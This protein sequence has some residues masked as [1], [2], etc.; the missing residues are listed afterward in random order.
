M[1]GTGA[2]ASFLLPKLGALEVPLQLFGAASP[3]L[4]ALAPLVS[5]GLGAVCDASEVASHQD[6][7]VVCKSWQ[8]PSKVEQLKAAPPPQRILVLQNGLE[9]ERD[10]LPLG[11][12]VER[13]LSTYGV[14]STMPG[15]VVGG[16][17]GEIT[18][19]T[20]SPWA[21]L[22]RRAGL[23]V[24]E[25]DNITLAIWWKLVVNASLNVVAALEGVRNGEALAIPT[26]RCQI[27]AVADEVASL[28]E[29]IG[30]GL[31]GDEP[32]QV[33]ERVARATAGNVCSTLA[34]LRS[35][36]PTEYNSI[37]GALLRLAHEHGVQVPCL[38]ALDRKF[39]S[40]LPQPSVHRAAS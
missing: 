1:I 12:Q 37:N 25:Q 35:S 31:G 26:L 14:A 16:E 33:V 2:V 23:A 7:L 10:W 9:P 20:G 39:S 11:A 28:A 8:N 40:F 36:R 21:Q 29:A 3:R 22:L 17:A 13:A 32:V 6:W 15:R 24:N 18:V 34:D 5:P 38:E 19:P 30:V 4:S 27:L